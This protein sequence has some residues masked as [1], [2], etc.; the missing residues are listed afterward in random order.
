M[1]TINIEA[2]AA[3]SVL[4]AHPTVTIRILSFAGDETYQVEHGRFVI[5]RA[6]DCDV[7]LGCGFVSRHHCEIV[8]ESDKVLVRDLGSKH[9]TFVNRRRITGSRQLK[10]GD[11][12]N[13]G[14]RFLEVVIHDVAAESGADLSQARVGWVPTPRESVASRLSRWTKA[15]L[16]RNRQGCPLRD[17]SDGR[18]IDHIPKVRPLQELRHS[19]P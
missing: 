6:L 4:L 14:L 8:V 7:I 12:I 19:A 15:D 18:P 9:G 16:F 2:T 1:V 5:G 10:S 3:Q 17:R 13:L 11:I